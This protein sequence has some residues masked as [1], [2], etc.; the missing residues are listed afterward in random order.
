MKKKNEDM[1]DYVS[2]EKASK[3]EKRKRDNEQRND[4]GAINPTTKVI[5]DKRRKREKH[6]RDNYYDEEE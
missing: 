1:R 5:P 6:K 3:K 4:W 2:Y